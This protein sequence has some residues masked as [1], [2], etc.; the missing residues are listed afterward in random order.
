MIFLS[1][2]SHT[3]EKK[4]IAYTV[5]AQTEAKAIC[6][7]FKDFTNGFRVILLIHRSKDGAKHNSRHERMLFTRDEKEYEEALAFLLEERAKHTLQGLRV[8]ATVNARDLKKA[9]RCFKVEQLNMDYQSDQVMS[10][11]YSAIKGRFA[12]ALMR[13]TSKAESFFVFDVD[14]PMTLDQ[15][16]GII[17]RSGFSDMIVKQYAT[18][19]GW[20]IITQP[21]NHT[22]LEEAIPFHRDGLILLK[23]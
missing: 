17:D 11:F 13:P 10:D 8:Y 23:F 16:L 12:S 15:A 4:P 9:I 21:F 5:E 19:N 2:M 6:E 1:S 14:S 22:K 20:H 7:E 3:R 18:K